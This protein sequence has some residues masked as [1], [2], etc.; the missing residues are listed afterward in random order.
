MRVRSAIVCSGVFA[1]LSM[2]AQ[3]VR[4]QSVGASPPVTVQTTP[5]TAAAARAAAQL[6]PLE[7]TVSLDLRNV[8][9]REALR[10]IAEGGLVKLVYSD[11]IVP[12]DRLVSLSVQKAT[13]RDALRAVLQKTGVDAIEVEGR[14]VLEQRNRSEA[15]AKDGTIVGRVT[16]SVSEQPL[17]GVVVS[18]NR[19]TPEASTSDSGY[20]GLTGVPAGVWVLTARRLGYRPAERTV[21]VM[22]GQTVR[23]DLELRLSTTRM[24]DVLV[25]ATGTQRR[26]EIGNDIT[27]INVDSVMAAAPVKSITDLLETRV[28]GLDVQHSSGE[29]GDPARLRLRGIGSVNR[30]NDPIVIVD[31]IRIFA[32]QSDRVGTF[33][34]TSNL[35]PGSQV[36]RPYATPSPLDQLDP[37][38]VERIEVFKGPSAAAMYGPD[39]ANGVIVITTKSGRSGSTHWQVAMNQGVSYQ[40]GQY[41]MGLFRWGHMI[42]GGPSVLCPRAQY[43]CELDSLVSFQALNDPRTSVFGRGASTDLSATVSGG[44]ASLRYSVTG[45]GAQQNGLLHLPDIEAVR[46]QRFHGAPPPDWMQN[47][48]HLT[49]WSG[50]SR[51]DADIGRNVTIGLTTALASEVQ[52]RSSLAGAVGSLVGQYIDLSELG[53][54]PVIPEF[55]ERAVDSALTLTAAASLRWQLRPW[56][57]LTADLGVNVLSRSDQTFLPPGMHPALADSTGHFGFGQGTTVLKTA[58]VGTSVIAPLPWGIRLTTAVGLNVLST[59]QEALSGQTFDLGQGVINPSSFGDPNNPTQRATSGASTLG[60]YVAPSLA[61]NGRLYISNGLRFDGGSATGHQAQFKGFPKTSVSWLLSDERFFPFKHAVN[62][63]RLR[64]AY[65]DAPVQPGPA[66]HLRLYYT[67]ALHCGGVDN[68]VACVSSLGNS[69]LRPE[70]ASE[71]EGGFDAGLFDDRITVDLTS[72]RK[73]QR[74]ALLAVPVAASVNGPGYSV[75]ENI[76]LVRNTGTELSIGL[77]PLRT[78]LVTWRVQAIASTNRNLLVRLAPGVQPIYIGG[79]SVISRIVPGYPLFGSWARPILGYADANHDGIIDSSEVR[80]GDSTVYVGQ[81]LPKYHLSFA[82]TVALFNRRVSID[83]TFDYQ[84]GMTQFNQNYQLNG[85]F[86]LAA[87]DPNASLGEQAAVAVLNLTRGGTAYGLVQTVSV[88]RFNSLAVSYVVPLSV[89]RLFRARAMSVALMGSNLGLFSNYR[90]KDPNVSAW[91]PGDGAA[92]DIGELPQPRTWS[93]GVRLGN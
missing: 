78:A 55:Y 86:A 90:G 45:S 39:A 30:N 52:Q 63:L 31:G 12:L 15:K 50:S 61:I 70:R 26:I 32:A 13:V 24:Q 51:L 19:P 88:L 11:R 10:A 18:I 83:A 21:I 72:Y 65:G 57:P 22:D 58:N 66:D 16:D 79:A 81:P 62:T 48:D 84:N 42:T 25:T 71:V 56:L 64:V 68:S 43:D 73:V 53:Q 91:G 5:E 76:G 4:A 37:N 41:P 77:E 2:A 67:D 82:T 29:P 85:A 46:F 49:R 69:K 93:L 89:A 7:R 33:G 28:P 74:D 17:A 75:M 27:S 36:G 6:P 47:P 44:T 8:T 80:V 38:S 1:L 87:N 3:T 23:V 9:L 60:W 14:I 35:A 54:E 92:T 59:S 34:N 40:P 20:Y